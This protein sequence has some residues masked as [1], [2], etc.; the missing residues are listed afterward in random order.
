MRCVSVR[1]ELNQARGRQRVREEVRELTLPMERSPRSKKNITPSSVKSKP[2]LVKPMPISA[3]SAV[4]GE[5]E[6][7]MEM[8]ACVSDDPPEGPGVRARP[9]RCPLTGKQP[10]DW[11]P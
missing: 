6:G 3:T 7:K 9:L 2:K 10:F 1:V 4:E 8:S 5:G 11:A